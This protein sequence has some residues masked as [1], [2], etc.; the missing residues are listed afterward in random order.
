MH[1]VSTAIPAA[2]SSEEFRSRV[3]ERA[4]AEARMYLRGREED[5]PVVSEMKDLIEGVISPEYS[6]RTILELLQNGHD[7]HDKS[8]S[9]GQLQV[10]LDETNGPYGTLYVVNGGAP[11][12]DLNFKRMTGTGRSSKR[13]DNSIGNKGIG[14]KSVNELSVAPEVYSSKA[15][16]E[17]GL[18]GYRFRFA[19]P[20]DFDDIARRIAPT[21]LQL[22]DE[23]R[24]KVSH[25]RVPVPLTGPLPAR[26]EQYAAES[27]STV[28]RLPLR[29]S[30]ALSSARS[31]IREI[32]SSEVPFHLFLERVS[33][34]SLHTIRLKESTETLL[35][36]DQ[37]EVPWANTLH[38]HD[39]SVQ[40]IQLSED[41]RYLVAS[42]DVPE[43]AFRKA[44][45]ES[46][47]AGQLNK[48]W[49]EW[50]GPARVSIA[51]P[52]EHGL[53][54]GRL[55]TH[56]PM[57]IQAVAP[58]PALVNAPFA[59]RADR[60]TLS[61][62]VPVNELLLQSVAKICAAL[63]AAGANEDAPIPAALLVDA[64]SWIETPHDLDHALEANSLSLWEIP[65]IPV[66]GD[67]AR[68]AGL[69]TA[70]H[71]KFSGRELTPETVAATG[72]ANLVDPALSTARIR[73]L[74][75]LCQKHGWGLEPGPEEVGSW[76]EE[77]ALQL[78]GSG[79]SPQRWADFYDDLAELDLNSSVLAG[80]AFLLDETGELAKAG[81]SPGSPPSLLP[82]TA[83]R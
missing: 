56:L 2:C 80:R 16:G 57:G 59:S 26:V 15:E 1:V 50:E 30:E 14:F 27:V 55:Y 25:L 73:R 23:L 8:R 52:L 38:P 34:I 43:G 11:L 22:A 39:V 49:L 45:E 58:L 61:E 35:I 53:N 78:A 41:Q 82:T 51:F 70:Y 28:I 31:Q 42:H 64:A 10:V 77:V 32:E 36:R 5:N 40:E 7:A 69:D 67:P 79:A 60:R 54:A 17:P 48:N 3:E 74:S 63:L 68:K 19:T 18:A 4:D 6:E 13:P 21:E 33:V 66:I 47:S 12:N 62:S 24:D 71:W 65:F 44:I 46:C 76:I 9:D 37:A 29:S 20:D 83:D 81:K 75:Q 72:M